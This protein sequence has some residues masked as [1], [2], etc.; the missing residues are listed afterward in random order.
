MEAVPTPFKLIRDQ[1]FHNSWFQAVD[2]ARTY[3]VDR[4]IGGHEYLDGVETGKVKKS[5]IRDTRQFFLLGRNALDQIETFELH[6]D[7]RLQRPREYAREF[8]YEFNKEYLATPKDKR[9]AYIYFNLLVDPVDQLV[10]LRDNLARQIALDLPSNRCQAITWQ[11][12]KHIKDHEPPCLQRIQ[13][14]YLGEGEVE[15]SLEWRSRD[16]LDAW[17][18]NLVGIVYMLNRYVLGPNM[19][20]IAILTENNFSLHI[21]LKELSYA[22]TVTPI[23]INPQL[24]ARL[25]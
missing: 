19:C 18:I 22:L 4:E 24:T 14:R 21:Y 12:S 5:P 16:V 8:T 25:Y 23:S 7:F 20:R 2:F 9:F 10:G 3:G 17:Q 6:P 13:I 15:V 11:P 1:N